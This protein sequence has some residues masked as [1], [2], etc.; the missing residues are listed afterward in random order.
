MK[1]QVE[2]LWKEEFHPVSVPTAGSESCVVFA[3]NWQ[4]QAAL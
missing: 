3:T 2:T 4:E 1:P